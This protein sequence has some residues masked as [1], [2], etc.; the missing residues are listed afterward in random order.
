MDLQKEEAKRRSKFTAFFRVLT[1]LYF[2]NSISNACSS[3]LA[4]LMQWASTSS[5]GSLPHADSEWLV[6]ALAADLPEVY[7][8]ASGDHHRRNN[9]GNRN[10]PL[11]ESS[12]IGV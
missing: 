12:L 8:G 5:T 6:V 2:S 9:R 10:G 7:A 4:R 3:F 11:G 1:G